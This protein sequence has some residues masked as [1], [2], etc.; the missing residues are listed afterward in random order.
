MSLDEMASARRRDREAL[1]I[2]SD[3]RIVLQPATRERI[4]SSRGIFGLG[5]GAGRAG[6]VVALLWAAS[7]GYAADVQLATRPWLQFLSRDSAAVHFETDAAVAAVVEYGEGQRLDRRVSG[8]AATWHR[9]VLTG[10]RPATVYAYRVKI[11]SEPISE[12]HEF[13]TAFNFA[14]GVAPAGE[15]LPATDLYSRAAER[16]LS[17]TGIARGYCLVLG[18]GTGQLAYELAKRSELI[19]VGADE[20]AAAI[21]EA[22]KRLRAAGVYGT[23]VTVR[24]VSSLA[25]LPFT[26]GFANLVVSESL[27]AAGQCPGTAAEMFRVLRPQGGV[28]C[29][30]VARAEQKG[31]V[32]QWLKAGGVKYEADDGLWLTVKR[33]P[34]PGAAWWSHQYGNPGNSSYSGETLQGVS[35]TSDMALQWLGP[36]GADFGLDRNPRMPAPLATNGRLF[37]QGMN[38]LIALDCYNGAVLWSLEIPDLRRVNMPRDASNWCADDERLFVAVKEKCLSFDGGTGWLVRAYGLPEAGLRATHEWGYVARAGGKLFGSSVRRGTGYT[39]FMLGAG[40]YDATQGPG[41]EK[42]CSDDLFA[43]ERDTGHLAWRYAGGVIINTTLAI[44]DGRVYLVESRNPE[45]K[46]SE[47]RRIGSAQLWADQY[48]VA[49]DAD[50]GAKCWEQKLSVEPGIAAF[51]LIHSGG[52]LVLASSASGKYHLSCFAASDG[53]LRWTASQ[54]WLGADHG[55]HI[56]HPVV[57]GDRAFLMPFGY[58]MKTGAVVTDKMP[59]GACGTVA[60]TT[61]A[62]IY[63]VKPHVS[64]WDFAAGKL[65]SWPTLRPSCWISTIPAG[66]MVLSPEGGGGCSCGGFLEVSCGFLPKPSGESRPEAER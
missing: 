27:L 48:L 17:R 16:I 25:K 5:T 62:L 3:G 2:A 38:R 35:Q 33:G 20:D 45:I 23:R 15:S 44:G 59:R 55:A 4:R 9:L 43:Y 39:G 31:T 37:H 30:G 60:A 47:S 65:S 8:P 13:D 63:R 53:R 61:R 46:A 21:G 58:D 34:L 1:R 6:V 51:Y 42:V 50:G 12:T 10:L 56:Q 26:S 49:L 29:L 28:A 66:G 18:C 41:T 7:V 36:P 54:A 64:L 32:E 14:R 19:V 57:V 24:H 11:G 52:A 40:W 22:R